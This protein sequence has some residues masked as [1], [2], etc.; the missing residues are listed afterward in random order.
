MESLPGPVPSRGWAD[1][2]EYARRLD[3]VRAQENARTAGIREGAAEMSEHA[4]DL[5]AKL[6]TQRRGLTAFAQKAGFKF[7]AGPA[8][9]PE[10][11]VEPQT[12]LSRVAQ[13]YDAA[14]R[15]GTDAINRALE[16]NLLP[17][18]GA[19]LRG[20]LVYGV[21]ALVIM[22]VQFVG[23]ATTGNNPDFLRYGVIVP[24]LGFVAAS[25]VL[26]QGNKAR[27]PDVPVAA[28][29][30]RMG[31]LLCFGALPVLFGILVLLDR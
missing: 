26:R 30:T 1:Y 19:G 11:H 3:E 12:E 13:L 27:D 25:L 20:L 28:L 7:P 24:L 21:T 6:D 5:H 29:P 22:V 8:P 2:A 14:E 18:T 15:D 17:R 9:R 16:P 10:G 4:D 31:L 23:F